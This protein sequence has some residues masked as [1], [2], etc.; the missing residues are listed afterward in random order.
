MPIEILRPVEW[1]GL[2]VAR[3]FWLLLCLILAFA[4]IGSAVA[5]RLVSLPFLT[6]YQKQAIHV[7]ATKVASGLQATLAEDQI[8]MRFVASDPHVVNIALGFVETPTYLTDRLNTLPKRDELSWV[9]LFDAYGDTIVDFD[10]RPEERAR[11]PEGALKDFVQLMLEQPD[12]Q[13]DPVLLMTEGSF[14]YLVIAQPVTKRGFVEGLLVSGYRL[15][16]DLIFPANPIT[17]KTR[18]L[19]M[20]EKGSVPGD[21]VFAALGTLQLY[22]AL[23]PDA[24]AVQAAG[25]ALLTKSV[26]A[27]AV[28]LLG[29][30]G[31]FALLG[32][33]VIIE[34]HMK[35]EIQ[36]REL[37]LQK[38]E[39]FELAEIAK[40]ANDS[41]VVTDLSGKVI[42]TNPA[43]ERLSGYTVDE[44]RG[45]TPGSLLQGQDTNPATVKRLRHAIRNRMPAKVEI[46]NYTRT[47]QSYWIALSLSPLINGKNDCYGF[48]AI[49]SNITE[50][51]LHREA[52]I[53][54][55]RAIEHQAMHDPLTGLPNRRALDAALQGRRN[56]RNALA[57]MVRIDLDHFKYV[58]DTMG[59]KAGDFALTEVARILKEETKGC[60]LAARVGGDEFVL[61]L[62]PNETAENGATLANRMLTRI[63]EPKSFENRLIRFGA[64]FGIASSEG[65]LLDFDELLIGADAA[66]Y[67]AKDLGRNR[68]RLYTP[69]LHTVVL[70]RRTLARE[71]R[72]AVAQQEFEPFFQPQFDA[73]T[74]EI[75][76]VETLARWQS[77]EFGLVMPDRF[78]PIARQLSILEDID[79]I[80]FRK[81]IEQIEGLII[82]GLKIPKLSVNVTAERIHNPLVFDAV[83]ARRDIIPEIAFEILESV[84]VEEQTDLFR[85][86]L[87]RLRDAGI[88]IEIDDFGSGHASIVGLMHLR[89]DAMKIDQRLVMPITRD[90]L[91]KGMLKSIVEMARL[92]QLDVIAEGVET[93]EHAEMLRHIGVDILQGYAFAKPMDVADLRQ[94]VMQQTAQRHLLKS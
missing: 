15:D 70:E 68:V 31:I 36:K 6:E 8:L 24:D 62:G 58:N 67:E 37:E 5:V 82:D 11:V 45:R 89:P 55:N 85:F 13:R 57:T 81:S 26:A 25:K 77:S 65:G 63:R 80:I 88:K 44:T 59:H 27:I 52:L 91:A 73:E 61:L 53:E 35:L 54:A 92:M 75:T 79:D 1:S 50:A 38:M 64:S 72:R 28:V 39:L 42:W 60:D 33:R 51:R 7:Q 66:L 4:L 56:T 30:F 93:M 20:A 94:F 22:V 29:A 17:R 32:R 71:L 74:F 2:S 90:P 78:L 84:L 46:L 40:L 48:V 3:R 43:F 76:G 34:P 9:T 21:A 10:V 12:W 47:G 41:I 49:S 14:A 18:L 23:V 69:E 19:S 16:L 86:G 87:D 83:Q